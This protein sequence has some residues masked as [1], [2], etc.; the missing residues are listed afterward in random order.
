MTTARPAPASACSPMS[1]VRLAPGCVSGRRPSVM[2]RLEGVVHE[3]GRPHER[4]EH[5]NGAFARALR[6]LPVPH[7]RADQPETVDGLAGRRGL[8]ALSPFSFAP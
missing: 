1:Y 5:A 8:R 4:L 6:L 3:E 2:D 7:Q